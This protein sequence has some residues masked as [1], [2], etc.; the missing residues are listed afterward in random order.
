[1][2]VC[3]VNLHH[4][5]APDAD[6]LV[7]ADVTRRGFGAALA[8][9]GHRV[10]VVQEA[11][12]RA[13]VERDG[14]TWELVP[15][16]A[17]TTA[18]RRAFG[19]AGHP[20][21][22]VPSPATSVLAV[23]DALR[24]DVIH[25]FDLVFYP[26]LAL[27]GRLARRRGIP[28]V[29]HFHGGAPA[30][31]PG[32]RAIARYALDRVDR[33]LFTTRAR[34]LDW[35]RAG[36][37]DGAR[38]VELV[39]TSTFFRARDRAAARRRTG[40][41][42]DPLY[43]CAGRLDPVKDPLTTLDG[44]ARIARALPGA[45]LVLTWTDAPLLDAVRRRVAGDPALAGRVELRGRVPHDAMEDLLASADY[46]LQSSVREV[47]GTVVLEA[48][49]C[50]VVPVITDIPPFRKLTD[51][52]RVGRLFPRGDGV[53]LAAQALSLAEGD[54]VEQSRAAAAWFDRALAFPALAEELEGI[55]AALLGPPASRPA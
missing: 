7:D 39:E 48:L 16:S 50:G 6:A 17:L 21:P 27:L 15:P 10:T 54:R 30:R 3:F 25:S 52:G 19:L 49:A 51:E 4:G 24:P 34:G 29:A 33:L 13:R 23:V 28:L 1:M 53:A 41:S 5:A 37:V 46:L 26:S 20:S 32:Y 43:V 44:F 36:L 2:H 8:A 18:S 14:V 31:R 47:C 22:A 55:Y 11:P 35:A 9:R 45:R 12:W 38:V 42:G 40:L